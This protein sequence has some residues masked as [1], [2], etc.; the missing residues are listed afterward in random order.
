[1][2]NHPT[3]EITALLERMRRGERDVEPVVIQALYPAMR[4]IAQQALN[5][6][7]GGK[8]TLRA[9][10][11]AHEAYMRLF[12]QR[13]PFESRGH[14]LALAGRMMRRVLVDLVRQRHAEKRGAGESLVALH[15]IP[16]DEMP[17]QDGTDLLA[18]DQALEALAES[19]PLAAQ[20]VEMRYF[21]GLTN[22]EAAEV[23][24]VGVATV[25]RHWQFGRAWLHHRL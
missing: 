14:F 12:G 23:L 8:V 7:F 21:V 2:S 1:M 10:E 19:D 15:E 17:T 18:L 16:D 3:P 20:V 5:S 9:T 6:G 4:A 25:V 24:G 13:N 11:L 22:E